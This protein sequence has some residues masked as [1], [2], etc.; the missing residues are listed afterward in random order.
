MLPLNFSFTN[1][2]LKK[3][4]SD[5]KERHPKISLLLGTGAGLELINIDSQIT[6]YIIKDFIK[7]DSPILT[8]HDSYVVTVGMEDRL[9]RLM[10]D[11][12]EYVTSKQKTKLKFNRNMTMRYLNQYKFS[13]GPD[14]DFYLDM[15][16]DITKSKSPAK[17]YVRR[18]ERHKKNFTRK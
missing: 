5:I 17:G 2:V 4:L 6:E 7:T 15:L 9:E 14:R 1:V 11:A 8:I 13:T 10:K 3:I 18:L 12:F 16:S